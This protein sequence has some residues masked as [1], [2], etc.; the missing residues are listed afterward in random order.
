MAERRRG[1]VKDQ[2]ADDLARMGLGPA[3]MAAWL[4]QQEVDGDEGEEGEGADADE[5]ADGPFQVW[6]E[7]W[8][9]VRLFLQLQTQWHKTDTGHLD[10]L[11]YPAAETLMRTLRLP[12]R[13]EL[14]EQ[15]IEMEHAALEA[16]H[17]Q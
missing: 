7:N 15:L 13:A 5:D 17:E 2:R 8:P 3:E 10:G 1:Q 14:M 12:R 11:R 6:P 4:A 9:V 16:E